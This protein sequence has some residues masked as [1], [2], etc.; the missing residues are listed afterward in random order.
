MGQ[1]ILVAAHS[2]FPSGELG[3]LANVTLIQGSR[4]ITGHAA[5]SELL[6]DLYRIGRLRRVFAVEANGRTLI[7]GM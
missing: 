4:S 7:E 6:A 5:D 1:E 2:G 3:P